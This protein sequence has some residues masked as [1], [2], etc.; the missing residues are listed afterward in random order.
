MPDYRPRTESYYLFVS[1][2]NI[3]I[4]RFDADNNPIA[5]IFTSQIYARVTHMLHITHT[6]KIYYAHA[7]SYTF[8]VYVLFF[9]F[10]FTSR[11]WKSHGFSVNR[12]F[13]L[14]YVSRV[15]KYFFSFTYHKF[16]KLYTCLFIYLFLPRMD[17]IVHSLLYNVTYAV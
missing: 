16:F 7:R 10:R 1:T 4:V 14:F 8:F 15:K 5:H 11:V 6:Y 2:A 12:F 9:F 17:N 3:F 13:F